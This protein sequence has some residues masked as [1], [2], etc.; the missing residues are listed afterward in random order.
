[1]DNARFRYD[2]LN[3]RTRY[4]VD[5][6]AHT[7]LYEVWPNSEPKM[8]DPNP[9]GVWTQSAALQAIREGMRDSVTVGYDLLRLFENEDIP[10]RYV[11]GWL[12]EATV[13]YAG[14][15]YDVVVNVFQRRVI[16][17]QR[18]V[19]KFATHH[20]IER[21]KERYDLVLDAEAAESMIDNLVSG[22]ATVVEGGRDG[23]ERAE[24]FYDHEMFT[25]V[26]N[27]ELTKI[28]TVTPTGNYRKT[29]K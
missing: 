13:D 2:F 12:Y 25:V 23:M 28:V 26:W 8:I 14:H 29:V 17:F 24:L 6:G 18:R 21:A 3:G 19:L 16:R 11:G 4:V 15:A 1:M 20:A 10:K 7:R 27:P 5:E 22:K 9:F